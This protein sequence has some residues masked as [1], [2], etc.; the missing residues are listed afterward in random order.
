[1]MN[2]EMFVEE[3][4][5]KISA[6]IN[7]PIENIE[8]S[9]D[10]DRFSPTGDRL[11][12]KFAE[13]DDAYEICGIHTKELFREFLNGTSF[14]TILDSTVRDIRQLQGQNSYEKTKK[15]WNYETVKDS[16]F[17]RLL[18][19]DDNS[20]ELSNAVYKRIGD[21]VQVLYMKVSEN[22]GNIMSTKIFKSVVEKW[23]EDGLTLSEDNILEEALR[24]TERMY[25]PRIYRWEQMIFNP[26]YEGEE[27]M[28][29]GTEEAISQDLIGNCLTTAKKTNTTSAAKVKLTKQT[30]KV[31]ANGK[32]KIKVSWKK[33]KNASG[34]EI[35]YST[36]KSFKGKKTIIV[37]SNKTTS[38]VVKKLTSKKK[39]FVKVRSYKQVGKTKT[40]GAYS[41]VKT[42]KVK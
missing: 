5:N 14:D 25:P 9:K 2:Y 34:Y 29:P 19:Y 12:V 27:F 39:Y 35:T 32:K 13:H 30:A 33:D 8:F 6:A 26:E 15:I 16:L 21:I 18:N 4:K 22:D 10:G 17:I 37:K 24:N 1:M 40:Y 23:K 36:K 11:L 42:I 3:L 31:K 28:S 7:I 41:K 20:K 38:K